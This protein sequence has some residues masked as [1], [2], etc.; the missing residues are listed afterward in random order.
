MSIDS[1]QGRSSAGNF[2]ANMKK[3]TDIKSKINTG[4]AEAEGMK[5]QR[6]IKKQLDLMKNPIISAI[7]KTLRVNGKNGKKMPKEYYIAMVPSKIYE[8]MDGVMQ[9]KV[10]LDIE[11]E[12]GP[13]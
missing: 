6:Y 7:K 5:N 4:L 3:M 1:S 12:N 10:W 11:S 2:A 13:V 8:L 9:E